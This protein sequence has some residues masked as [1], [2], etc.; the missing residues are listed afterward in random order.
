MCLLSVPALAIERGG[1]H[2]FGLG[3]V[4]GQPTGLTAKLYLAQPF[5]LQ[6]GAGWVHNFADDDGFHA[7]LDLLWHPVVLA[8]DA[9]FTLPF[10][11][12]VGARFL[13]YDYRYYYFRGVYYVDHDS[14]LGVRA[15]FG[16]LMDFNRI[17]LDVYL[18]VALV[19][20]F[21]FFDE[22]YY[23]PVDHRHDRVNWN[24]GLG[25]RYYF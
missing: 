6:F 11:L 2:P 10:Y 8:R 14:R 13:D 17:P 23:D 20:D 1:S 22:D 25:V 3:V 18:E 24:A 4:V 15:P 12:G 21:L 19:V 5:A 16:L 7:N 9:A